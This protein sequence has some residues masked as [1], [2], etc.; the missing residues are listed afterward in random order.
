[1]VYKIVVYEKVVYEKVVNK[2]SGIWKRYSNL[3]HEYVFA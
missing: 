1:M 2:K 3:N